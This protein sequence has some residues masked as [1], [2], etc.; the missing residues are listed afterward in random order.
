[1]T[2]EISRTLFRLLRGLRRVTP[3]NLLHDRICPAERVGD[4][5]DVACPNLPSYWRELSG[6][7]DGRGD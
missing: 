3:I 2:Y 7:K 5:A 6:C 4:G 1:V